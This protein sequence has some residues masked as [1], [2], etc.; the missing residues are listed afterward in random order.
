VFVVCS[1]D[2]RWCVEQMPTHRLR[3]VEFLSTHDP[4]VDLAVLA[5]CQHTI[6]SVGTFGW[7]AAWL[8]NGTTVYYKDWP[9][10]DS[11]LAWAASH[12]DY[13]PPR[14]IPL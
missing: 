1:D 5:M 2:M 13:F 4:V 8:S 7:W 9:R 11:S 10:R 12:A 14:W 6:I 3:H